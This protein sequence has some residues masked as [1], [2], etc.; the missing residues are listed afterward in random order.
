MPFSHACLMEGI[1]MEVL[2][3]MIV[4]VVLLMWLW[5]NLLATFALRY[6][7]TLDRFQKVAQ[8]IIVWL[9]PCFGAAFVLH[10][11]WQQYPDAIPRHWIPWPFKGMI[12]GKPYLPNPN[13]DEDSWGIA[14]GSDRRDSGPGIGGDHGSDGGH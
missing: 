13:S 8:T 11:I 6:D 10:L 5:L 4:A 9:V 14:A 1:D 3:Y 12:Y 7:A 2:A